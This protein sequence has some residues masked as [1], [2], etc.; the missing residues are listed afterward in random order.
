MNKKVIFYTPSLYPGGVLKSVSLLS[1]GLKERGY[2]IIIVSNRKTNWHINGFKHY[3]LDSGDI[4][5]P[6]KLKE[7]ILKEN[8]AA[9]FSNLMPQNITLSLSKYLLKNKVKTKFYGIV[10][11]ASSYFL[12]KQFYKYPY[13]KFVKTLCEN[14]D[15]IISVSSVVKEDLIK[16][17]SINPDKSTIIYD[18]VDIS[19][20]NKKSQEHLTEEEKFIFNK[21]TIL[22][23]GRFH[24]QKRADILVQ[25]FSEILK[26]NKNVNLVLMGYGEEEENLKNLVKKLKIQSNVYFLPYND[27]PY[28]YMKN[29]TVFALTSKDEGFARVVAESLA[30]GTPVVAFSNEYTG[31]KDIIINEVNGLLIPFGNQNEFV[32]KTLKLLTDDKIYQTLKQNSVKTI[33]KFSLENIINKFEKIINS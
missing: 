31:H 23:A 3:Y 1:Q 8:P 29:A 26:I 5:R 25:I 21:K 24:V 30:C 17:F 20:I 11:N 33:Q 32:E 12:Y 27:N 14:L 6:F 16:A 19:E 28:K 18:P 2:E 10:R 15:N 4:L 13:R 9:V 22:Y 7:I